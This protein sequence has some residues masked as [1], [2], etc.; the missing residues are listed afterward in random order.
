MARD[1]DLDDVSDEPTA[2]ETVAVARQAVTESEVHRHVE[3]SG[4]TKQE[5]Q[6]QLAHDDAT[7]AT[8]RGAALMD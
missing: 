3:R 5:R 4:A 6:Q 1:I 7:E 8:A 2:A